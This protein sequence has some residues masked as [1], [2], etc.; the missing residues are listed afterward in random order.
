M[1]NPAP[2]DNPPP[3]RPRR[4][5]YCFPRLPSRKVSTSSNLRPGSD[6]NIV[7]GDDLSS[8]ARNPYINRAG[9]KPASILKEVVILAC[10]PL[11]G[12]AAI[13]R[14]LEL[15]DWDVRVDD[16]H[17]EP[18]LRR[19]LFVAEAERRG[20][21]ARDDVPRHI[22]D[23]EGRVCESGERVREEVE[24]VGAAA[25]A[26][27]DDLLVSVFG[28]LRV[29]LEGR[30]KL[31][32]ALIEFPLGPVTSMQAPQLPALSQLESESAVPKMPEGSE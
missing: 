1:T 28:F 20:D 32:I 6:S 25:G 3:N 15:G 16:L 5:S 10:R 31:T 4:D 27:V 17:G 12:G 30:M 24:V 21:A 23:A 7:H 13:R 19:P 2:S 11:P 29:R 14:D 9:P 18:V 8:R 26:L 22:D